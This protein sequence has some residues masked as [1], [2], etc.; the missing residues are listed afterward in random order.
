[1]ENNVKP[2]LYLIN[3]PLGAGK[4]TFLKELLKLPSYKNARIIENEFANTSIDTE[5]LH[6]HHA[7]VQTITGVCICCSTGD[8]LTDALRTLSEDTPPVIIE[9][10]GVANS[11]KLIEKIVNADMLDRYT[12]KHA[13]FILDAIEAI[14]NLEMTLK[15]YHHELKAADTVLVSKTDLLNDD[16]I[17]YLVNT[18]S[19][20]NLR[21]L[22]FVN[23]GMFDHSILR[24]ESHI[25]EYFSQLKGDITNHEA[26]LSYTV[27]DTSNVT[28]EISQLELIWQGIKT[29]YGIRRMKGNF[30]TKDNIMMH[31]EAT[32]H[33]CKTSTYSSG[34]L[35]LVVIGKDAPMLTLD[36]FAKLGTN[37]GV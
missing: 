7:E 4:T 3:G 15:T 34:D 8:E 31:V 5:Q 6:D 29:D 18:L 23:E 37:G 24:L 27:L 25:L 36:S 13:I 9:A 11:L 19:R 20:L 21:Q 22:N 33:Q 14:D 30:K 17:E 10:T 1:M 28:F 2:D 32:P 12:V 35:K 26:G 16:Q